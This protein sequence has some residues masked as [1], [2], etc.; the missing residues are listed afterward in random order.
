MED[1][2]KNI[3]LIIKLMSEA[4]ETE[5]LV[6]LISE[7]EKLRFIGLLEGFIS[8]NKNVDLDRNAR[9]C[10]MYLYFQDIDFITISLRKHPNTKSMH[11]LRGCLYGFEEDWSKAWRDFTT[12]SK[13]DPLCYENLY[14]ISVVLLK[15]NKYQESILSFKAFIA[16][17]PSDHRKIPQ[18]YYSMALAVTYESFNLET[19]QEYFN[20]GL[21]SEKSQLPCFLPYDT[22]HKDQLNLILKLPQTLNGNKIKSKIYS[23][24]EA[25]NKFV[26]SMC[27]EEHMRES[28]VKDYRRISLILQHREYHAEVSKMMS[29]TEHRMIF[30]TMPP[31][32]K[33]TAEHIVGLKDVF[34]RDIDF[35][36]DH[37]LK[38]SILALKSIDRPIV[39]IS[40][41]LVAVD[42]SNIAERVAIY[43][44]K[45]DKDKIREMFPVGCRFSI[46][47]PYIRMAVDGI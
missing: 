2:A 26:D 12:C 33:Q 6:C 3:E 21:K 47:N 4:Y 11:A 43:N 7:A 25:S 44:L 29:N 18:A 14:H 17:A 22:I 39:T 46:L 15:M 37:V 9:I 13:I 24:I 42:D 8:K 36:K 10:L 5:Y 27:H 19:A 1:P 32:K 41:K 28:I 35:T 20:L 40:T 23:E 45:R 16:S 31:H 34:L 38:N 30:T